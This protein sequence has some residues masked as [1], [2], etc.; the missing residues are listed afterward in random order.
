MDNYPG[1]FA[2]LNKETG[3]EDDSWQL[4][5]LEW[6]KTVD[7]ICDEDKLKELIV[8]QPDG[9]SYYCGSVCNLKNIIDILIR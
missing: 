2:M 5:K 1:L 8:S 3:H 9:P 6:V 4:D 7:W